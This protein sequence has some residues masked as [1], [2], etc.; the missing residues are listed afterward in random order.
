MDRK[1][2]ESMTDDELM[3]A[4]L[5]RIVRAERAKGN[6][7]DEEAVQDCFDQISE[8]MGIPRD[9][10][11][12]T[13]EA[14]VKEEQGQRKRRRLSRMIA[15]GAAA[16][17][18]ITGITACSVNPVFMNWLKDIVRMPVG[19]SVED[20][21]ITYINYGKTI[22]VNSIYEFLEQE[23]L[24]IYYPIE[25]YEDVKLVKI[26]HDSTNGY[27]FMFSPANVTITFQLNPA[28]NE[29]H[30]QN[31]SVLKLDYGEFVISEQMDCYQADGN[32]ENIKYTVRCTE[33]DQLIEILTN[34]ERIP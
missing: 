8:I 17:V 3:V 13:I 10:V 22:E 15:G 26:Y 25:I 11:E 5:M 27:V 18:M 14:K 34:M 29:T 9:E 4:E 20:E 21:G 33:Y 23:G 24:T 31:D 28:P 19:T 2:L 6:C 30:S 32:I 7:G 16:V 12:E 1:R